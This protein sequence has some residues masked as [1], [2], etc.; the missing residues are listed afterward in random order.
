MTLD[1]IDKLLDSPCVRD[2]TS[3]QAMRLTRIY[4]ASW[5]PTKYFRVVMA[6]NWNDGL[7]RLYRRTVYVF[8]ESGHWTANINLTDKSDLDASDW[9]FWGGYNDS[10]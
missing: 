8:S 9:F 4:R 1:E 3:S 6:H 10:M 7:K 2:R 5:V